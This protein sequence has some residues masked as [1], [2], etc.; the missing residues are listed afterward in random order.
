MLAVTVLMV[1][2]PSTGSLMAGMLMAVAGESIRLWAIGFAGEPTR[3]QDLD[4]PVLITSGPY[5][6]TR[7]P[8]Y[9][10]NLL[11]GMAVAVAAVGNHSAANGLLLVAVVACGLG[12]VYGSIIPL[13]EQFLEEQFG[14]LYRDYK[15]EVAA[16]IPSNLALRPGQGSF[17]LRRALTYERSS[18]M[19]WTLIWGFLSFQVG[20]V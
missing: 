15:A 5:S 7:N 11:N 8:L 14:Q 3:K 20:P 9:L 4:A 19:W 13:E 16:L 12:F 1:A 10:G 18:L 2:R 17:R 6:L